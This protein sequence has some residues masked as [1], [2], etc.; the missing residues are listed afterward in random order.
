M[1]LLELRTKLAR[2]MQRALADFTS[3]GQDLLVEAL[4]NARLNAEKSYNWTAQQEQVTVVVQPTGTTIPG[5][6]KCVTGA[7]MLIQNEP[8]PL[9][10][11]SQ[12]DN[13]MRQSKIRRAMEPRRYLS[14]AELSTPMSLRSRFQ[15][16]FNGNLLS[17]APTQTANVSVILD[18]QQWMTTYRGAADD[19]E[20]WMMQTGQE[21]LF[22]QAIVELNFL[23]KAFVPRQE[24]NIAPPERLAEMALLKMHENDTHKFSRAI[25]Y[26]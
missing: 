9:E 7:W 14:D 10:V 2:Y 1:E 24:G 18:T 15:L 25:Y 12:A 19:Y 17:V 8:Y 5:T 13:F 20:D 3:G 11:R 26:K 21:Y 16:V 22:W 23:V 4:E 6:I